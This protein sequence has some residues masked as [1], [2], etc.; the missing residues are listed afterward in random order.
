MKIR[1]PLALAV[2]LLACYVPV[3]SL[4]V[5]GISI[6]FND[7]SE[8]DQMSG[9]ETA[10]MVAVAGKNWFNFAPADGAQS[11]NVTIDNNGNA[12][13]DVIVTSTRNPWG[14]ADASTTTQTDKLLASYIDTGTGTTYSVTLTGLPYL[15]STVYLIMSG[16][17]GTFTAMNVNGTSWTWKD[18]A[19]A[20]GTEAWGD[21]AA[22]QGA[23]TLGTNVL[24][25]D[26]VAGST[27][28]VTN[29]LSGGRGTLA[30]IQVVDSYDGTY[31]YRTLGTE[32]STWSGALWS[33]SSG[34]QG[35]LEWG[36]ALH[37]AVIS[38]DAS[39]STL[40]LEGSATTEALIV[41]AGDLTLSGSGTLDFL[42]LS[43]IQ[44]RS[45]ATLR[46]DSDITIAGQVALE[47]TG[48]YQVDDWSVFADMDELTFNSATV[49]INETLPVEKK[50]MMAG[51]SCLESSTGTIRIEDGGSLSIVSPFSS[52]ADGMS[53]AGSGELVWT[54]SATLTGDQ[55]VDLHDKLANFTG[56]LTLNGSGTYYLNYA[57]NAKIM[58]EMPTSARRSDWA[59]KAW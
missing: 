33:D 23:L 55:L 52:L 11:A 49:L 39:G 29:V 47:G 28:V 15:E 21:R 32:E 58:P 5:D 8:T 59:E 57:G 30:G 4:A 10:G 27:I 1:L 26:G 18:G 42:D 40:T 3:S 34:V 37:A 25:I 24:Q 43:I 19:M 7:G 48:T 56:S 13:Q 6:N 16:D 38:A 41:Q 35:S 50:L 12:L 31:M 46:L 44:V 14:P 2:A 54:S 9:D 36:G 53:I 20:E 51:S 22:N 45:G 17:G